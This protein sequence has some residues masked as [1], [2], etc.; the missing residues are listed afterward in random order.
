MYVIEIY[1]YILNTSDPR[2]HIFRHG[3]SGYVNIY[4][5]SMHVC[6]LIIW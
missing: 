5:I 4:V 3:A 6:V 1:I 2:R